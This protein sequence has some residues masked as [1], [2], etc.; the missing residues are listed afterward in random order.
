M[1]KIQGKDVY[2]CSISCKYYTLCDEMNLNNFGEKKHPLQGRFELAINPCPSQA[3]L[4]WSMARADSIVT[5]TWTSCMNCLSWVVWVAW[6]S[7]VTV[8]A[9]SCEGR[10]ENLPCSVSHC[11]KCI[12]KNLNLPLVN[13]MINTEQAQEN[14]PCPLTA[15]YVSNISWNLV[16]QKCCCNVRSCFNK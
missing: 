10:L 15:E 6:V 1:P 2:F 9:L 16:K 8:I 12:G 5:T 11:K 7:Q 4:S 14:S 3:R 13:T